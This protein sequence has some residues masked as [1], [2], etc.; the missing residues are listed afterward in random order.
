MRNGRRCCA[1]RRCSRPTSAP[2]SKPRTAIP[3]SCSDRPRP[4]RSRWSP[5]CADASRRTIR[6]CRR[7]TGP[8]PTRGSIARAASTSRSAGCRRGGGDFHTI[9]D[10][11]A[12]AKAV[13]VLQ[14]RRHAPF[15]RPPAGGLERRPARLGVFHDPGARLG[16]GPGPSRRGRAGERRRRL[17][18]RLVVLPLCRE[19]RQPPA[20]ESL[21]P[22][23]RHAAVRRRAGLRGEGQ[24]LVHLDRRERQR[25]LLRHRRRRSRHVRAAAGRSFRSGRHTAPDRTARK[26]R[27]LQRRRPRRRAVHPD[28]RRRCDRLP[29]RHRAARHAGPRALARAHPASARRLCAEHPALRQSSGAARAGQRPARRS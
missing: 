18:Q 25:P 2:I 14:V 21:P 11:D 5:R 4:C 13:R 1:T 19:G 16:N 22:P 26:G 28:Q 3:M 24:R 8:T 7:P 15:A 6:A 12:L 29:H 20:A 9:L 10:G 27:A 17:G 23:S